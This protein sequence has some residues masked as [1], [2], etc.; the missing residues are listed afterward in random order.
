MRRIVI[1]GGSIAAV[2]A[3]GVLRSQGWDGELTVISQEH[4]DPYSRV[5]LSKGV[6]AG[7]SDPQSAA[8]SKMSDDVVFIRGA[9]ATGLDVSNRTVSLSDGR[10]VVFEG[11]VIATGS[12]ARR[13]AHRGQ[14]GE[15][16]LRTLADARDI[17]ARIPHA[18]SAVVVGSG[19]LAMEVA[20]TLISRG[21]RVSLVSQALPQKRQLGE[22]L[23]SLL[24]RRAVACGLEVIVSSDGATLVG[25]PVHGVSVNGRGITNA[26]LVVTAVGDIP[27]TEWLMTSRLPVRNGLVIDERCRTAAAWVTAAGDVTVRRN[28]D[29]TYVRLPHWANAV[30]Q[31]KTAACSLLNADSAAHEDQRYFWTEQFGIDLKIAGTIPQSGEPRVLDGDP[32]AGPALLLWRD[33]DRPTAA[34]A[35]NYRIPVAKLRKLAAEG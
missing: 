10:A 30:A 16:V 18:N 34:A 13:L 8:L 33:H 9:S 26:D 31:A 23:A 15:F 28:T 5:P 35:L 24:T 1:V 27:A 6:L 29:G 17:C 14:R 4:E 3:A 20:S 19:F 21:V 2:T 7:T 25:D 11:A 22:W 32:Q 12:H